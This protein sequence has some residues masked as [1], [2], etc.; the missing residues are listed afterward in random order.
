MG[1]VAEIQ[2]FSL[3][4][5]PGI[6]GTV[7]FKGCNARCRWC[8]N[9]ETLSPGGNC[10]STRDRCAGCGAC[11]AFDPETAAGGLPPPR[12]KLGLESAELCFS[13][14]LM[15]RGRRWMFSR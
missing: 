2:R 12:E 7:F 9:P 3:K 5:G 4:D 6:R 10:L 13:G 8:H 15:R 1:M 11:V 14:A